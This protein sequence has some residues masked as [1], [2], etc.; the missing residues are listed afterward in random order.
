MDELKERI[1][2]IEKRMDII[3]ELTK[4]EAKKIVQKYCSHRFIKH[5]MSAVCILCGKWDG[6]YCPDS[7]D[8]RCHY[9]KSR[10]DCDFCHQ[11][12]ERK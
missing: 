6:W 7:E 5:G 4:K 10:D 3:E 11:P 8:H 2:M 12:E 9:S 1:K